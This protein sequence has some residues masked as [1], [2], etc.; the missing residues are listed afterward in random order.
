MDTRVRSV[1]ALASWSRRMGELLEQFSSRHCEALRRAG[2]REY[3][4]AIHTC[5]SAVFGRV[6]PRL[7][8]VSVDDCAGLL[9]EPHR[10]H[11]V[12]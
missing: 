12:P 11:A 6:Q 8:M 4:Q 5:K 9:L 7:R 10:C 3:V 2:T 1:D